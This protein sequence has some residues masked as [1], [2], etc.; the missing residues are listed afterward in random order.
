MEVSNFSLSLVEAIVFD[1]ADRLFELGFAEQLR[2]IM[3]KVSPDRQVMRR[4]RWL[5]MLQI[6]FL[7]PHHALKGLALPHAWNAGDVSLPFWTNCVQLR[8]CLRSQANHVVF[9]NNASHAGAVHTRW[10]AQS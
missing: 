9:S 6:L 2:E 4:V 7:G 5:I 3:S 10:P 8:M 1:E